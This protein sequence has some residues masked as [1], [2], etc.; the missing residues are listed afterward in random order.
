MS[1]PPMANYHIIMFVFTLLTS[2]MVQST[3]SV[4]KWKVTIDLVMVEY[5]SG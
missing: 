2:V 4:E 3:I 5:V 1:H